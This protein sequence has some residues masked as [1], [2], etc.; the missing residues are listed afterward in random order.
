M[1]TELIRWLLESDEPWTRYRTLVDLLGRPQDDPE[2]RSTRAE[3]LAHPQV[4][5]LIAEAAAWPGHAL[6]RH[7]DASHTTYKLSTLA[8]FGVRADDPG[9]SACIQTV[10]S[11]SVGDSVICRSMKSWMVMPPL[12]SLGI[13]AAPMSTSCSLAASI[14]KVAATRC[15]S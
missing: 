1:T 7:N 4:Q 11:Q 15:H 9:L 10:M 14:F 8:D 13:G 2:V 3:M 12:D 6:K 5:E